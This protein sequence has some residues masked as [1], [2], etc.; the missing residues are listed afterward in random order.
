MA[1]YRR[2]KRQFRDIE[3]IERS[4]R[5]EVKETESIDEPRPERG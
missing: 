4:F 3:R 1:K 2:S 5:D